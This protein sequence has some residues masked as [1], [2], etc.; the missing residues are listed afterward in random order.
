MAQ[1]V[2]SRRRPTRGHGILESGGAKVT[3]AA[4]GAVGRFGSLVAVLDI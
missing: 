1:Y 2:E 4:L 3:H